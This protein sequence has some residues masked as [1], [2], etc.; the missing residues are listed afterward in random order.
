MHLFDY[1]M[2]TFRN[3]ISHLNRTVY[4]LAL[5]RRP[6]FYLELF[7]FWHVNFE[8]VVFALETCCGY[9]RASHSMTSFFLSFSYG[10]RLGANGETPL[11]WWSWMVLLA[12]RSIVDILLVKTA[13]EVSRKAQTYSYG[14][15][16]FEVTRRHLK[17]LG[18]FYFSFT[19]RRA[20]SLHLWMRSMW[21]PS[22]TAGSFSAAAADICSWFVQQKSSSSERGNRGPIRACFSKGFEVVG[23]YEGCCFGGTGS[24]Q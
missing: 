10:L 18:F 11:S 4:F 24:V 6:I 13:V 12:L 17:S 15:Q 21:R 5:S 14:I 8:S 19:R 3:Q 9:L 23:H 20:V 7:V 2:F 16:I 22:R 1:L